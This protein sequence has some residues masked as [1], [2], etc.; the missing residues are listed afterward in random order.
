MLQ[1][2]EFVERK[3]L[4]KAFEQICKEDHTGVFQIVTEKAEVLYLNIK[5]GKVVNLKYRT[6]KNKEALQGFGIIEK[7]KYTFYE[8]KEVQEF[9]T[10]NEVPTNKEVLQYLLGQSTDSSSDSKKV[11]IKKSLTDSVMIDLK[12]ILAN[13]IGPVAHIVCEEVFTKTTDVNTAINM[14]A[15]EIPAA[16]PARAFKEEAKRLL[17][18]E[19]G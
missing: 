17:V 8:R 18:V 9:P 11:S 15:K 16:D 10:V 19:N 13:H 4:A 6:R 2:K 1:S 12:K 5:D 7:G 3:L 14:L